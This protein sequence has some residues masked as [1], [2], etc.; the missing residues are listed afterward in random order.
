MWRWLN[1]QTSEVDVKV[2]KIN[3]GSLNFHTDMPSK[4][5]RLLISPR[6]RQIKK[7]ERGKRLNVKIHTLF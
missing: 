1:F 5:G 4:D 7:Y 3:V 2:A 6:L